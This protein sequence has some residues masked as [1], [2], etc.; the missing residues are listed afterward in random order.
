MAANGEFHLKDIINV[1][2]ATGEKEAA[3]ENFADLFYQ[4][5]GKVK[6]LSVNR[7]K[8]IISGRKGT[9]K[10]LLA[11]FMESQCKK[12][13]ILTRTIYKK[14]FSIQYLLEKGVQTSIDKIELS[15]FIDY[16]ILIQIADLLLESKKEIKKKITKNEDKKR[17]KKLC[18]YRSFLRDY[19]QL[20]KLYQDLYPEGTFKPSNI[21]VEEKQEL[22]SQLNGPRSRAG[23]LLSVTN[24]HKNVKKSY[25]EITKELREKVCKVIR[26]TDATLFFD[27]LDEIGS[28]MYVDS[29]TSDIFVSLLEELDDINRMLRENGN[30][31][32]RC[33]VM[34]RTDILDKLPS[35]SSN[36]N[37]LSA[38]CQVHLNWLKSDSTG[39]AHPLMDMILT[40]I[41]RKCFSGD[42]LSNL[43]VCQKLFPQNINKRSLIHYLLDYS[44]G[45]PRDVVNFLNLIIQKNAT[46]YKFFSNM[47]TDKEVMSDYSKMFLDDLKSEMS[48]HFE[49]D[50]IEGVFI[51]LK[52]FSKKN[53][54]FSELTQYFSGNQELYPAITNLKSTVEHLYQFGAL[55]N[56]NI[57][58]VKGKS[59]KRYQW[60]YREDGAPDPSFSEKFTVHPAL[61]K[62][63]NL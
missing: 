45:R 37:K 43:Q 27:D 38:D 55:G 39:N 17:I 34:L 1:G 41:N 31:N 6:E 42:N 47:F 33:F 7:F 12:Y 14:D 22:S 57:R 49:S 8:F 20:E 4:G 13:G 54:H 60:A 9:G 26:Y 53:F 46:E 24:K 44:F 48:I 15:R 32:S 56:I 16:C 23:G 51:L 10:T 30:Q 2:Y 59:V 50:Y 52:K 40:K 62:A 29:N 58:M 18:Q 25:F 3:E 35:Y 36:Y 63:L 5:N 28:Q 61:Y 19:H 11:K 21:E